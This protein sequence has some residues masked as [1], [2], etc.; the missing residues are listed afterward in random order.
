MRYL[1]S[2]LIKISSVLVICMPL[3]SQASTGIQFSYLPNAGAAIGVVHYSPQFLAGITV[4]GKIDD[5]AAGKTKNGTVA[6]FGGL[7]HPLTQNTDFAYGLGASMT[8][9][10]INGQK[11]QHSYTLSGF[12]EYEYQPNKHFMLSGWIDPYNFEQQKIAN[13]TTHDHRIFSTGGI[14]VSYLF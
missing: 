12:I 6:I 13:V 5:A 3:L 14:A 1:K 8:E 9:G 4:G 11:I 2:T 7:R 10:H